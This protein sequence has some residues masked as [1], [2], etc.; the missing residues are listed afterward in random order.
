MA[1]DISAERVL[2]A[3]TIL[4]RVLIPSGGEGRQR[5]KHK[6]F[7]RRQCRRADHI[8]Y[9]VKHNKVTDRTGQSHHAFI[10]KKKYRLQIRRVSD[11]MIV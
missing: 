8:H 3:L 6:R 11:A 5:L 1:H 10:A 4:V 9:M 2:N 7:P